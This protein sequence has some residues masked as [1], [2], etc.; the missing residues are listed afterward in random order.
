[1]SGGIKALNAELPRIRFQPRHLLRASLVSILLVAVF[2]LQP[3]TTA[4]QQVQARGELIVTGISGPTTF[5]QT[6]NGAR[7][8]QY[9][10]A[11]LFAE[12]LGV[13]LT[14]R[15][16]GNT[17]G[18][19]TAIRHNQ[20]D[21]AI[22]G[23][24]SDDTRLT[25]LR[26]ASPYMAVSEQLVQRLDRPLLP[27]FDAIGAAR[28]GVIAGSSEAQRLKSLTRWRSDIQVI[29]FEGM[30]PLALLEQVERGELDY[31]ALTSSEFDA[32]RALFPNVGVSL[33]LQ[34]YSELAWAFL[35][36]TD[37]SLYTAAQAFLA[38]KQED[39]TLGKLVAFYSQGNT[40]DPYAVKSFQR[41]IAQRL[42]RYQQLFEK[43]AR[44]HGM[45]W[46]LLAAIAYQ[47]SRWE[48][49]AVSPTGVQGLMMLTN[50]TASFMGV[51][52]RTNV[53]QSIR[54]GAAYYKMIVDNLA[55]VPEPDRTWMALAAYNMGPGHI[56]RA[57][58]RAFKA[59]TDGNKWLVVSHHL[60]AMAYDARRQGR[61][62]PVGQA[63]HYVQQ[64]RRYYDALL[65]TT[66]GND[67][68]VAMNDI[69]RPVQ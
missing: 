46:H 28:I 60:R 6:S 38:R 7:G 52:D 56:E 61:N 18:V 57:R 12:D 67:H 45:D 15:D 51:E 44:K 43:N 49:S 24:A 3:T 50:D 16:A 68:R 53:P 42:P 29:E 32:R 34:D 39:G 17:D 63:L 22:S 21:I 8:L 65:L 31:A 20:T 14:L 64:V 62:I 11:R 58:T 33:N 4:L 47:E 9:E 19:L 2:Q 30:D 35:K 54:G 40:F 10:L 48:P 23:L 55:D 66:A 36:T 5:Y 25:R 69:G 27:T 13:K 59:G 26:T 1:M 41:D 37:K